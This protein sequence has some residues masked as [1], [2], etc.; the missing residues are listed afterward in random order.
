M[1]IGDAVDQ[2]LVDIEYDIES[3]G[4]L[5][6]LVI[7]LIFLVDRKYENSCIRLGF[8]FSAF[9]GGSQKYK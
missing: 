9:L 1:L 7:F 8:A 2:G 4:E 5:S 6:S 3:T